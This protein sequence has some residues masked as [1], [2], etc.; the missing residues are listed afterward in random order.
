[1]RV[2]FTGL[3]RMGQAI[4]RRI[5]GG[6]YDLIVYNRSREKALASRRSLRSA[7]L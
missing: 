1:M 6:G 7:R 4:A 3:G 5:E 2:G